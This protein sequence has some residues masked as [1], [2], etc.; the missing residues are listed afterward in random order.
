MPNILPPC[1]DQ[2]GARGILSAAGHGRW[3][4]NFRK[5]WCQNFRNPQLNTELLGADSES[6]VPRPV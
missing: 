4:Q 6:V 3:C 2:A 1:P 5:T